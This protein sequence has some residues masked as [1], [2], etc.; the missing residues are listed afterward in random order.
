MEIF[1]NLFSTLNR[2][3]VKYLVVGGVAVNIYG[4]ERATADIDIVIKLNEKNIRRFIIAAKELNLK[5]RVP[6]NLDDFIY[7]E[8]RR[9][10]IE[11]KGMVVF[12]LYDPNRPFFLLDVFVEAPFIFDDVYLKRKKIRFEGIS[13]PIVP[14]EELIRMK[15]RSNRPQD[16]ADTFYLKKILSDWDDER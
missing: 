2:S 15:E 14:I 9:A 12:G 13:I 4:I 3:A 10:W 11:D 6:V 5:P 7:A 16:R 1:K 8:K